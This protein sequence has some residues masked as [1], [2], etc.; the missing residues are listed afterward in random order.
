MIRR[1]S[2]VVA[3][4]LVLATG[5]RHKCC[6]NDRDSQRVPF[7]PQAPSS[8]YLLPPAGVPTTPAPTGPA[9]VPGVGPGSS[10]AAPPSIPPPSVEPPP[11]GRPVP[12]VL[13]PDPLP[14]GSSSR[15]ASPGDAGLGVL[16]SPARPKTA[17]PA[18]AA[19]TTAGL[20]GFVAVKPG[21]ATGRKPALEGFDALKQSGYRSV[22]YL[23]PAGADVSAAREVAEKRSLH[24][25]AIETTPESLPAALR[26]FNAA[27]A[28]KATHPAYVC[29]DD[30][31]RTGVLWYLHFRTAESMNDDA[32]R[33]RAK[34]LGLTEQGDE[35]KAF[36]LATQRYLETR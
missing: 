22:F 12:E 35:A 1:A 20:T 14:G 6:L 27:V 10:S 9:L 34:P 3:S 32:A 15:S 31:L 17:E 26:Q 19:P 33:I 23:H 13:F 29:D 11:S 21:V 8:P 24:F 30:G 16:G 2:L 28:D 7:R 5:C 25:T 4:V 36:A 18:R